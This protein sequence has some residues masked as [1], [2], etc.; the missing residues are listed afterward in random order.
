[1]EEVF[2]KKEWPD[3]HINQAV[4]IRANSAVEVYSGGSMEVIQ[5]SKEV[6]LTNFLNRGF[7]PCKKEIYDAVATKAAKEINTVI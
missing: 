6:N 4:R 1:M 3:G 2:M 7:I 5:E